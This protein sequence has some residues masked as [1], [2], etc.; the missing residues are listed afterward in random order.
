VVRPVL[1]YGATGVHVSYL[2][3]RLKELQHLRAEGPAAFDKFL[4]IAVMDF[5]SRHLDPRGHPLVVDGVVG[6][7]TWWAL[8][9]GTPDLP[10]VH[11]VIPAIP[12]GGSAI[13]R[14]ALTIAFKER[15]LGAGEEGANNAGPWIE[16]Y[17]NGIIDAPANWCAALVSWCHLK[18]GEMPFKYSLGA[19]DIRQ[20]FKR[21][22][23]VVQA[24]EPGDLVFWWRGRP[25]GWMG[26][27]GFVWKLESGVLHTL[28]G[29]K[30]AFPSRVNT[31]DYIHSRMTRVLGFGR[32]LE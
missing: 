26:H 3:G 14:A 28:E 30:G 1:K 2:R 29:N 20:Q 22:G 9:G 12:P 11:P 10:V 24:P 13:G 17:L 31:F 27:I 19:R 18:T 15:A 7:L 16:K 6:S 8:E 23:W 21:K 32:V 4:K 5:Q 25:D